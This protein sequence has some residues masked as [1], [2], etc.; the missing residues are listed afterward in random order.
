MFEG[1]DRLGLITAHE[2]AHQWFY[3]LVGNN[4][5]RDPWL[6]EGFA[7]YAGAETSGDLP[8]FAKVPLP[9]PAAGHMGAPMSY[10]DHNQGAYFAGVYA[11]PVQVLQSFGSRRRWSARCAATWREMHTESPPTPTRWPR[12]RP[13]F[14]TRG[15]CSHAPASTERAGRVS[16]AA[17]TAA[18]VVCD[19][20]LSRRRG[21]T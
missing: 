14:R 20:I 15:P 13:S 21:R 1:P 10:W 12:F 3:S 7:S 11:Q 19:P 9:P 8:F 2:I 6:D 4:Q 5:A 18:K 17:H 16:H